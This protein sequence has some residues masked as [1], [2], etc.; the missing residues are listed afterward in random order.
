MICPNPCEKNKV[1]KHRTF[2]EKDEYCV[3]ESLPPCGVFCVPTFI[4]LVK[5]ILKKVENET[6]KSN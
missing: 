5:E 6:K 1:C 4:D 2:H 3:P